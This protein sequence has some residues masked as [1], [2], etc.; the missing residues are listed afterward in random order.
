MEK[1]VQCSWCGRILKNYIGRGTP[2][3][4]GCA[5]KEAEAL[6]KI[7]AAADKNPGMTAMELSG[8][9]GLYVSQIKH[10][11]DNGALRL[12]NA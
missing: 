4:T 10:F 5:Q 9:T 3:C 1:Y 7:R 12:R 11:I 6:K 8:A 2:Y